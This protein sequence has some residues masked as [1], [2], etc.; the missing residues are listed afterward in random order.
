[1]IFSLSL[2]IDECG[3]TT[4]IVAPKKEERSRRQAAEQ[5]QTTQTWRRCFENMLTDNNMVSAAVFPL[6]RTL[7]Q[8]MACAVLLPKRFGCWL[9]DPAGSES[10]HVGRAQPVPPRLGRNG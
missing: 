1:L 7:T 4:L 5:R 6:F 10:S 2:A 9:V 8:T 3:P